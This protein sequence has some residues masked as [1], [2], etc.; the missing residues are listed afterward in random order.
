MLALSDGQFFFGDEERYDRGIQLYRAISQG[1][2]ATVRQIA[3]LPEHALFPWVGA[4][5]TAA[6]H[7]L[8]QFTPHGDW[9]NSANIGFTIKLG[10][11]VLSSFST[12]NLFLVYRIARIIGGTREEANWALLLMAASNTAFYYAR[13]LL[14]YECAI[15]SAL[16]AL[17]LGL[18]SPT[19]VR[20]F[21]CGFAGGLAYHLYNGYWY[22]VPAVWLIHAVANR[23]RPERIWLS[24]ICAVG[25]LTSLAATVAIGWM[26][27]GARYF[28]QMLAFSRSVTQGIFA[29][30][31]SFPWEYLW[32]SETIFGLI[33]VGVF[34]VAVVQ[35]RRSGL[36]LPERVIG[37]LLALCAVYGLLMALSSGCNIFVVYARTV[38]PWIPVF[39]LLGGWAFATVLHAHPRLRS[40]AAASVVLLAGIR[41]APH[42]TRVFP[43]ELEIAVLRSVGN[44][45]H[46]LSVS[47][48]L[49]IPLAHPVIRPDLV[50]VNAQLLYPVREDLGFPPGETIL[51][52]TH[53]LTY[54]PFQY[55]SHT[56]M[57]RAFL[58]RHDISMRL[59]RLT[60][61]AELPVDLPAELRF[62]SADRPTGR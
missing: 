60:V 15:S 34:G 36:P 26:A 54:P 46:T 32:H 37:S 6:Q 20:A 47:G 51:N 43:R 1:D 28:Q 41:F 22:L 9:S 42:F 16:I 45:K 21:A 13:H 8:A 50:L 5:V 39:G 11:V 31:W 18:R 35:T 30:G 29:E 61:P 17:V 2:F 27:G 52:V 38:K 7:L 33:V 4:V 25:T 56:P 62:R 23:S 48:S 3:G 40:I 57:E 44:P 55:E 58:R 59:I 53:P 12:L 49:Y 10:A 19:A 24:T 14:P